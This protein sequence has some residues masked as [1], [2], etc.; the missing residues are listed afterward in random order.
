MSSLVRRALH[1]LYRRLETIV[2]PLRYLFLE[3]TSRCNLRCLHCGSDCG[4]EPR[5]EELSTG[6]WLA[7]VD[8]LAERFDP[9]EMILVVT[10]GEP[11]CRPELG[12]ILER[13][14]AR[15]FAWG[16]VTNGWALTPRSLDALLARGLASLTV[17]L[18][19]LA[20]SHDWLRGV[21]GS[22]ERALGAIRAAVGAAPRLPLFDVVTCANPRNLGEL[23]E[24]R[25]LLQAE[26]VPAWRLFTIFPKGRARENGEVLLPPAGMREVLD[27]VAASRRERAP[28]GLRVD[29][30]C[31]GYL[32]PALD[33]TVRDEP[34][35]CRAGIS[36]AS[37]LCDGA[38]SVCPNVSR[39]LVQGNV[40]RD[41][42]AE[43]WERRFLPH[44]DRRWLATGACAGCRDFPRCQGNSLHLYDEQSGGPA[45][46]SRDLVPLAPR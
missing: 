10:G 21:P 17:S 24:L 4:R 2:H 12:A 33:R 9:R 3:V 39:A 28:H 29:L 43:V 20:A 45:F 15:G 42:L 11:L 25:A 14:Q 30:S 36:I 40:R 37:I 32:P 8:R 46:C 31:E 38:I 27:F 16:M 19:G 1:P 18:D 23:G 26:G 22:F 5:A 6:E 34:Y 35:F 13:I 44:R 7:V 41:D